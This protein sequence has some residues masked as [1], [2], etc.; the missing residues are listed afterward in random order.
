MRSL[1]SLECFDCDTVIT[2]KSVHDFQNCKCG[3]IFVDGG[4]DYTRIGWK[5]GNWREI[6]ASEE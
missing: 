2:S 3:N 1:A 5:N 6:D 4:N